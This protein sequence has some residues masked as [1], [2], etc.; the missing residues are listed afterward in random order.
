MKTSITNAI[1]AAAI[2]DLIAVKQES[3]DRKSDSSD[4]VVRLPK[5][6]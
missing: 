5:P 4:L 2:G 1:K 6:E 3:V